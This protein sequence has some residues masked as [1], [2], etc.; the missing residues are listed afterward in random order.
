MGVKIYKRQTESSERKFEKIEM[1]RSDRGI[2]GHLKWVNEGVRMTEY[3]LRDYEY[4]K[5]IRVTIKNE[6]QN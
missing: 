1:K 6:K 2:E 5:R 4:L 3:I